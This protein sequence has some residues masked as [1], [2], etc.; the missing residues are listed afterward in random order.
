MVNVISIH[1]HA[2]IKH[3]NVYS[4]QNCNILKVLCPASVSDPT[5]KRTY[6]PPSN[7]AI[8]L[9]KCGCVCLRA[10]VIYWINVHVNE[11]T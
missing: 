2:S 9:C 10:Y 4:R 7:E 6:L 3:E 11:C 8:E 1:I 5:Q